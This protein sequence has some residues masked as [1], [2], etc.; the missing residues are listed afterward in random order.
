MNP[1]LSFSDLLDYQED[2]AA[3]K[4]VLKTS[5]AFSPFEKIEVTQIYDKLQEI[6][7]NRINNLQDLDDALKA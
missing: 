1:L 7:K 6:V 4:E 5:I 3:Q 2:I